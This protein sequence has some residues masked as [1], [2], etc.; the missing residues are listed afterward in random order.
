MPSSDYTFRKCMIIANGDIMASEREWS[1]GVWK[2]P[3][4]SILAG[5]DGR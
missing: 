2:F 1:V 3:E 4:S 5:F